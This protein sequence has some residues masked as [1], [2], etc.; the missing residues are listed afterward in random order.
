MDL[1]VRESE[2]KEPPNNASRRVPA[3]FL[4]VYLALG[5]SHFEGDS[6]PDHLPLTPIVGWLKMVFILV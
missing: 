3:A 6:R 4:S 2:S 5:F 1:S